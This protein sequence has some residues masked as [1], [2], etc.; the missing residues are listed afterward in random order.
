MCGCQGR[1]TLESVRLNCINIP[2][3][4]Y[5]VNKQDACDAGLRVSRGVRRECSCSESGR[6]HARRYSLT[7][8]F[9]DHDTDSTGRSVKCGEDGP[10]CRAVHQHS[11]NLD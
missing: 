4:L 8:P 9:D 2:D 6:V 10:A 5:R 3:G 11:V 1:T 7:V